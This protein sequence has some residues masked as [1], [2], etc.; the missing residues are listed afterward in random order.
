MILIIGPSIQA[1]GA[2]S[3]VPGAAPKGL[4]QTGS[5]CQPTVTLQLTDG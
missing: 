2:Q 1:P 3:E 5:V 4:S